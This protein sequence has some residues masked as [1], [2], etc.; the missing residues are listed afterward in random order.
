VTK[1]NTF[2]AE[3]YHKMYVNYDWMNQLTGLILIITYACSL[4][5]MHIM[6]NIMWNFKW[7][8]LSTKINWLCSV[9]QQ[10]V[11]DL[12]FIRCVDIVMFNMLL[13]VE[14]FMVMENLCC[15]LLGYGPPKHW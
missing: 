6:L 3:K 15:D 11:I 8:E 9:S 5:L 14:I 4:I 12:V 10:I 7:C 13:R 1:E 2:Q